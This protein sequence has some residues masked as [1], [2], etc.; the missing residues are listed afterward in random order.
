MP[1]FKIGEVAKLLQLELAELRLYH[2]VHER[3]RHIVTPETCVH[4]GAWAAEARRE[5]RKARW[6]VARLLAGMHTHPR[7]GAPHPAR[8]QRGGGGA[9]TLTAPMS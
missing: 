5:A 4:E 7:I 8:P 9:G 6:R 2:G 3:W 1:E